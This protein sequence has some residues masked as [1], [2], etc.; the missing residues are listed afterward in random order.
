MG[1]STFL[2][3]VSKGEPMIEKFDKPNFKDKHIELRIANGEICIY[4]TKTGIEK[5][6]GYCKSLIDKP[7]QGHIHLEDYEV[8]TEKSLKG[9]IAVFVEED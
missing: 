8:L 1:P 2:E 7:Q 6:L 4:L 9:T 3:M 5:L